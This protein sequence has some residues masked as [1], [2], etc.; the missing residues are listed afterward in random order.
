MVFRV[1]YWL[2]RM[3]H[4]ALTGIR[5]EVGNFSV[6]PLA[7]VRRLATVSEL[8]NHYAAAVVQARLPREL[9]PMDRGVR[10]AGESRMNFVALVTHGLSAISVFADRIGVRLLVASTA[11]GAGALVAIIGVVVV[12]FG[13]SLAVPGWATNAMGFLVLLLAQA[14]ILSLMFAVFI[15]FGRSTGPFLPA[16]DYRHFVGS[17]HRIYPADG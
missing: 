14:M 1:F 4:E 2:F 8:W 3:L 5:V 10:L 7:I 12:R 6:L 9:V 17:V 15:Q 11:L 13:T 16:R